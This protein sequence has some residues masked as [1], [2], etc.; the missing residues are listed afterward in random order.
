MRVTVTSLHGGSADTFDGDFDACLAYLRLAD[1]IERDR[2]DLCPLF[3]F[4]SIGEHRSKGGSLR[5]RDNVSAVH[6]V[7]GD[8]DGGSVTMPLEKQVWGDTFGQL[9]DRFGIPWMVNIAGGDQ[10]SG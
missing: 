1:P 5:N 10:T 7:V 8:Y 3:Q 2:K 6:A 9:T 4:A